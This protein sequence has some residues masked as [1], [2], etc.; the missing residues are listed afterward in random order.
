MKTKKDF[1][2]GLDSLLQPSEPKPYQQE[3]TPAPAQQEEVRYTIIT[4]PQ[5]LDKIKAIAYWERMKMK[6]ATQAAIE[7]Y[8]QTWEQANQKE[9][10]PIPKR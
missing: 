4:T 2:S 10:P 7:L 1:K 5:A 3:P 9:V 6:E 8:I